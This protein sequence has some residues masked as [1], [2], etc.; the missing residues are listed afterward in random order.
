[1]GSAPDTPS[2]RAEVSHLLPCLLGVKTPHVRWGVAGAERVWLP[3]VG[4]RARLTCS[5]PHYG[6][7]VIS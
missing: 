4:A 6:G 1:M 3:F 2:A 5:R 7:D